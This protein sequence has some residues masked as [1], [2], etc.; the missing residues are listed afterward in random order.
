MWV[1]SCIVGV[2]FDWQSSETISKEP[3]SEDLKRSAASELID[4][5]WEDVEDGRI[6]KNNEKRAANGRAL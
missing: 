1:N 6:S 5:K 2:E 3:F 4:P